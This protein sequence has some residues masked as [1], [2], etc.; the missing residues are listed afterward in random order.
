MKKSLYSALLL[1][2]ALLLGACGNAEN[3]NSDSKVEQTTKDQTAAANS[4]QTNEAVDK[5]VQAFPQKEM[6]NVVTTSVT[7]AEMLH[8]LDVTP[9]GLPTTTHQLPKEF[10]TIE[11]VGSP[12]EPDVEKIVSL[13][14]DIVVGPDSVHTSLEKKLKQTDVAS[15]YL[16]TDSYDDLKNGLTAL[17]IVLKKEQLATS[18]LNE[19]EKKEQKIIK[20]SD[21]KDRKVMILFGTGESFMLMNTNTYVGSLVNTMGAQNMITETS[22]SK[23]AYVPLSMENVVATNPDVILLVSHGDATV[24]LKQ[25]KDEVKKNGAW[26]QLKAFKEDRVQALDYSIFGYASI[27]KAPQALEELQKI[28]AK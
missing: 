8:I 18:Y 20:S 24:A 4:A 28:L 2:T 27:E 6:K 26:N 1:S 25:F 5:L 23:E 3:I 12:V 22:K 19:L 14:P 9:I 7:I 13:K 11:K 21:V 15:A 16:P 17:S 10:E